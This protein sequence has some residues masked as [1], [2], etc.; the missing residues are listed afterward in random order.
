MDKFVIPLNVYEGCIIWKFLI[1]EKGY[2][3]YF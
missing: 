3:G 1:I 2:D